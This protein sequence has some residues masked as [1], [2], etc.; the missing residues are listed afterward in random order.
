MDKVD[1]AAQVV[2]ITL[3][4]FAKHEK[5][6]SRGISVCIRT[7]VPILRDRCTVHLSKLI[8]LIINA[9]NLTG[10]RIV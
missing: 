3:S 1:N 4:N 10:Y 6:G 7:F 8:L 2:V 5:T 9:S